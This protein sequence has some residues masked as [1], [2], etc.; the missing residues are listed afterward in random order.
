MVIICPGLLTSQSMSF[1]QSA[2]QLAVVIFHS[3][4]R[5]MPRVRPI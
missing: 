3:Y 1:E 5:A 4:F 2:T